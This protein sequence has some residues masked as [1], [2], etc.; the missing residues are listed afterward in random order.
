MECI[1]PKSAL[2]PLTDTTRVA[3]LSREEVVTNLRNGKPRV[4][5][6]PNPHGSYIWRIPKTDAY[7]NTIKFGLKKPEEDRVNALAFQQQK[8]QFQKGTS[9]FIKLDEPEHLGDGEILIH[10]HKIFRRRF[11]ESDDIYHI[12]TK[13]TDDEKAQKRKIARVMGKQKNQVR[14]EFENAISGSVKQ[15][16]IWDTKDK[17]FYTK[18]IKAQ[19]VE[20]PC[21]KCEFCRQQKRDEWTTKLK[22]EY[23]SQQ[24]L[25]RLST[26]FTLTYDAQ[27]LPPNGD[28]RY[29]DAQ[30]FIKQ[31]RNYIN[32]K[33]N[34]AKTPVE[35]KI[36]PRSKI[37]LKAAHEQSSN[38]QSENT[39]ITQ[40]ESESESQSK[41]QA[42]SLRYFICAEYGEHFHRVHFHGILFGFQF[43]D[44]VFHMKSPAGNNQ[45]KSNILDQCW[46]NKGLALLG[47]VTPE[48][49]GYI[50]KYVNKAGTY[51]PTDSRYPWYDEVLLAASGVTYNKYKLRC[52][53]HGLKP[54]TEVMYKTDSRRVYD[55]DPKYFGYLQNWY[56]T[57]DEFGNPSDR[58]KYYTHEELMEMTRNAEAY[59]ACDDGKPSPEHKEFKSRLVKR[60]WEFARG[61]TVPALGF[62][63]YAMSDVNQMLGLGLHVIG[64]NSATA[65]Q[66]PVS[67]SV[68]RILLSPRMRE[69]HGL[70]QIAVIDRAR[71]IDKLNEK[72]ALKAKAKD[73]LFEQT[74]TTQ[75]LEAERK[76]KVRK[77]NKKPLFS[78]GD[79]R[80]ESEIA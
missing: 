14:S 75:L 8:D 29:K 5:R 62:Y 4:I 71:A 68:K 46:G 69:L 7:G 15:E 42:L 50:A 25:G 13:L 9:D 2:K 18:I 10:E 77:H 11:L 20:I 16:V 12:R 24:K 80:L 53:K 41:S 45:Y 59:K 40:S 73:K 51:Q 52:K 43:P 36:Q 26:A 34:D 37:V 33:T 27:N 56:F 64:T 60:R 3:A 74:G 58:K 23:Q 78:E 21:G 72:L 79:P 63:H 17:D 70:N 31:V 49:I 35:L 1:D 32:R 30:D 38:G 65:E 76:S 44:K 22:A 67:A 54:L 48:T 28:I 19:V 39:G 6:Q 55:R 47:D 61:S 57:P 66:K